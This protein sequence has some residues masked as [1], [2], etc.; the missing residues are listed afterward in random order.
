[1]HRYGRLGDVRQCARVISG[2]V[3]VGVCD[4]QSAHGSADQQVG[5]DAEMELILVVNLAS[6]LC[7]ICVFTGIW[8]HRELA[9]FQW[10]TW[11][12]VDLRKNRENLESLWIDLCDVAY[13]WKMKFLGNR[14]NI[15]ILSLIDKS[16]VFYEIY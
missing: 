10:S 14:G 13:F 4:V 8:Y 5:F 6:K 7:K 9:L 11:H 12:G 2:I 15:P 3:T 16:G 1:M